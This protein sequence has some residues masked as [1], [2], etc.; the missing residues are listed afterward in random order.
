M[1]Q[2]EWWLTEPQ[3][4][5]DPM[6]VVEMTDFISG[7][8][9]ERKLRLFTHACCQ[10][11]EH[12]LIDPRSRSALAALVRYADGKC[13]KVE[14]GVHWSGAHAA[15]QAIEEPLCRDGCLYSTAE[16]IAAGAVFFAS[17]PTYAGAFREPHHH[18]STLV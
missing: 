17:N 3:R 8:G 13:D 15:K 6:I 5:T 11:I 14:F 12:L 9:S 1:T 7:V 16:S 2:P 10:R 18:N 4:L